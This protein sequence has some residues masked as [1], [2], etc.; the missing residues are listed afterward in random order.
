LYH[1]MAF[2]QIRV[3]EETLQE[4]IKQFIPD[5]RQRSGSYF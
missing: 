2:D 4:R 5:M 1:L 3:P